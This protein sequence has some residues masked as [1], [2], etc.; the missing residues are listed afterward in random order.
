M[1]RKLGRSTCFVLAF[2]L[3]LSAVGCVNTASDNNNSEEASEK[4]S[5]SQVSQATQTLSGNYDFNHNGI[6][7]SVNVTE[8]ESQVWTISVI[9]DGEEIWR[10]EA[11]TSHSEWNSIFAVKKDGKDHLLRY[12]PYMSLGLADYKYKIFS[13]DK[14]GEEAS[15]EEGELA[16]DINFNSDTHRGFDPKEIA[17]FLTEM[18]SRLADSVILISTEKGEL[19]S[20]V[21]GADF[22]ADEFWDDSEYD[23]QKSLEENLRSYKERASKVD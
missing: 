9:E 22:N 2:V 13:L 4:T 8:V 21:S 6:L 12:T 19:V 23:S 16:F 10:D 15:N 14:N 7:E 3:V 20:D 5:S 18:D 17:D 1:K 11:G